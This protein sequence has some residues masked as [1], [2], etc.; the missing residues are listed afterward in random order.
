MELTIA[1]IAEIVK[2]EVRGDGNVKICGAASFDDAKTDEITF[3]G[4]SKFLKRIDDT[5]AGAVIVPKG[6][7][8]FD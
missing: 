7:E 8:N 4:Q 1:Q 2:G 6:F 5:D 3:A